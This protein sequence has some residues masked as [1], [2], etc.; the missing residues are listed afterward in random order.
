VTVDPL[1]RT[2]LPQDLQNHIRH[3]VARFTQAGYDLEIDPPTYVPLEIEIDICAAA[4]HFR[5]HVEEAVLDVLSNRLRSNGQRG[6]FYPD[7]FTFGQRLYLSKL[8]AAIEA[9]DGV[10]SAEVK[11]FQRFGKLPNN[12]LEQGYI[13][14]DRLEVVRLD[15]DPNFQENGVLR[16]NMLGGK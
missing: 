13:P 7:N 1:G 2:D 15:N 10:D 14:I 16:L 6:F 8:Y 12:E 11:V 5:G 4:D 9:V 3:W